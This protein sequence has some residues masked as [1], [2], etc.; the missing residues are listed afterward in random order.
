MPLFALANCAVVV[1]ASAMAGV[2][3]APVGQGIMAGLLVGK[4]LGIAAIC[5]AAIKMNLCSFPPGMNL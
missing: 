5:M 2:F 1:Q 3:T 4:P